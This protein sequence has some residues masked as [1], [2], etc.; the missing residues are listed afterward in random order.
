MA[1]ITFDGAQRW[2]AGADAPAVPGIDLVVED[3]EF[4]VLVGPSGCGK[5]TTLRM[6]AGLEDVDAGR[7]LIGDRDVTTLPPKDRVIAMVF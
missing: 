6:L 2:Y 1:S 5:T 4:L 3:G 7:I